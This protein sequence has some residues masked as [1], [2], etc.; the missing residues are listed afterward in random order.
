[1]PAKHE[2]GSISANSDARRDVEPRQ[3]AA[4]H[5][6]RLAHEPVLAVRQHRRRRRRARRRHRL[7]LQDPGAELELV[8]A[9]VEDRVVELARH[10]QRPP[11][12]PAASIAGDVAGLRA[13]RRLDGDRRRAPCAIDRDRR[14]ARSGCAS[15][16]P[17]ARA[18]S[19][20]TPFAVGRAVARLRRALAARSCTAVREL[21]RLGDRVDQP[22]VDARAAR[23]RLRRVVQKM[24]ARSCRTLRLSVTRVRPPVPGSTPSSGTS[25]SDTD[26]ERSSTST[27]SSQASASS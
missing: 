11:R 18:A 5:A 25:G 22:P 17:R 20:A 12:A 26:D 10:R 4:Q 27:I 15:A 16:D 9:Q 19:S 14:R 1:M 23:A 7:G 24:S 3:R 2:P 21:R 6:D 8:G 13:R